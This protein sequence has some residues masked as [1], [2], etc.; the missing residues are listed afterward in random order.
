MKKKTIT[1]RKI[2][3]TALMAALTVVG[4]W[5][6]ITTPAAVGTTSFHLGNIMCALAGL[7]LG[8]VYGA[9]AAGLGSAIFDLLHP[10]Y[11]S[12]CWITF[13]TKGTYGL[14]VGLIAWSGKKYWSANM[15]K[16]YLRGLIA[17]VAGALTYA[18]L[19]LSKGCFYDG[20]LMGGL[21]FEA[22]LIPVVTGK[23][24]ATTFNAVV[25]IIAAPLLGMG[26]SKGLKAARL[27]LE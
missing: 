18:I 27:S 12:E 19:Y 17:T 8:P 14:V 23:A 13:L 15:G 20:M 4:S 24:A 2:V 11:A 22:A 26:I 9:L 7:L 6:R 16:A 5:L 21:S 1:T 10:L 3:F 25:A